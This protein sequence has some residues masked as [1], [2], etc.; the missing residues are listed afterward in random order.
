MAEF[1]AEAKKRKMAPTAAV[2]GKEH[3]NYRGETAVETTMKNCRRLQISPLGGTSNQR[4][5]WNFMIDGQIDRFVNLSNAR[6]KIK[7]RIVKK[8]GNL[9]NRYTDIVAPINMLGSS[10]WRIVEAYINMQTFTPASS[11]HAGQKHYME[12]MLS[13][14]TASVGNYLHTQLCDLDTPNQ[15]E[16]FAISRQ[17]AK[18]AFKLSLMESEALRTALNFAWPDAAKNFENDVEMYKEFPGDQDKTKL[19]WNTWDNLELA[20]FPQTWNAGAYAAKLEAVQFEK[21]RARWTYFDTHFD[22]MVVDNNLTDLI[23]NFKYNEGFDKRFQTC[24]GSAVFDLYSPIPHDVFRMSN[25]LGPGNRLDIK[26]TRHEDA[27]VL[28]TFKELEGYKLEILDLKLCF[29]TIELKENITAPL[30]ETYRMNETQFHSRLISAGS[31]STYMRIVEGGVLPKTIILGM[32][33][34]KAA[35]GHYGF[36]PCYYPHFNITGVCL[37]VNGVRVPQDTLKFDFQSPNGLVNE[38][39]GWLFE[40]TGAGSGTKGNLVTPEGYRH[41]AFFVPFDL[42]P[43]KCNFEHNHD[44]QQGYI[45]VEIT[46]ASALIEPIYLHYELV[47]PKVVINDKGNQSLTIVDVAV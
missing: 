35:N 40:N 20:V 6:L 31:P 24:M 1:V 13:D 45:D 27:F 47:F 23:S 12:M 7:A 21:F 11:M 39:Y 3:F 25:H 46:F 28:N 17:T 16:N 9:L 42:S 30:R 38:G 33:M 34:T 14:N 37:I 32:T 8:D 26:L 41:G 5:P 2:A 4:G 15:Y 36:N 10:L 29:D 18:L 19:L 43:D 22:R 44:A